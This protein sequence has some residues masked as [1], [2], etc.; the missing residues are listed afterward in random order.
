MAQRI[1]GATSGNIAEVSIAG[2]LISTPD[3]T[4]EGLNIA[5]V[6]VSSAVNLF[7][8]DTTG[9]N[10]IAVQIVA[11]GTTCTVTYECSIDN[12]TWYG[13]A[14]Y[15]PSNLGTV[16]PILIST[17]VAL[18]VFPTIARYFRARVSTYTSGTVTA[19]AI[20]RSSVVPSI[21]TWTPAA[22]LA[23]TTSQTFSTTPSRLQSLATTNA[24]SLKATA[25]V[26]S[27]I[28]AQNNGAAAAYLKLYNK[29]SAP[30]VGTDTPAFTLL[31][32]INGMV[33]IA[34]P[35]GL[36]FS[37]G[38]AYAITA[39]STDADTTAVAANQVTGLIGWA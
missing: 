29:A 21:A 12:V 8:T 30:T 7:S 10:S 37:A 5:Q 14:G 13:C 32:P 39:L 16:A 23:K 6:S 15:Q 31:L 28:Y 20:L 9:Y 19:Q 1:V 27:S 36:A 2:G 3:L 4:V 18:N 11:A 38:I 33:N 17:T 35:A 24:T 26:L 25:G 22:P 34:P